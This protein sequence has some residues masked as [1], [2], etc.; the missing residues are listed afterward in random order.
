MIS[1]EDKEW[2]SKF[3]TDMWNFIKT[4]GD[5]SLEDSKIADMIH[6]SNVIAK[7]Y[8]EDMRVVCMLTGFMNGLEREVKK[9]GR[10]G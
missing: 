3:M 9:D 7:K 4:Y 6:D 8:N 5:R 10:C 2:M 1:Q